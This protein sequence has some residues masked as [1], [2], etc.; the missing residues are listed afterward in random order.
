MLVTKGLWGD[1]QTDPDG[2]PHDCDLERAAINRRIR[3]R[4]VALGGSVMIEQK[5]LEAIEEWYEPLTQP[6]ALAS[7]RLRSAYAL[8][9]RLVATVRAQRE[10]IAALQHEI[11]KWKDASGLECGGDPDA[12]TPEKTSAYW[13]EEMERAAALSGDYADRIAILNEYI[14]ELQNV[15]RAIDG[16]ID[17]DDR[18]SGPQ[19]DHSLYVTL[20]DILAKAKAAP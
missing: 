15:I 10:E 7:T 3:G 6:P 19:R 20:K 16:F 13:R 1:G 12:V 14:T 9:P 18:L 4:R 2:S 17:D 8:I 11:E 5:E